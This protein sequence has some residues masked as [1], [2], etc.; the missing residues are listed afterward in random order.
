MLNSPACSKQNWRAGLHNIG[1]L[2]KTVGFQIV[3]FH[4]TWGPSCRHYW[5]GSALAVNAW[6]DMKS[7]C[8]LYLFL[9]DF[10][11]FFVFC[12]FLS[13]CFTCYRKCFL[14]HFRGRLRLLLWW[15]EPSRSGRS[16]AAL[17][18]D[19]LV[20]FWVWSVRWWFFW[21]QQMC[22]CIWRHSDGRSFLETFRSGLRP[23]KTKLCRSKSVFFWKISL[24]K[25]CK[26]TSEALH[27]NIWQFFADRLF[28][29]FAVLHLGCAFDRCVFF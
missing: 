25:L 18:S 20:Q 21:I 2:K 1:L 27:M 17:D 5:S 8:V 9:C 29:F 10:C 15:L 4:Q 24:R 23:Q 6:D 7:T 13:A 22:L 19:A 3:V 26:Y 14:T 12:R 16:P 28:E 11:V